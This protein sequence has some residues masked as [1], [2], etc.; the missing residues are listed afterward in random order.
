MCCMN[1]INVFS[2][3]NR[4]ISNALSLKKLEDDMIGL[5]TFP[6][7]GHMSSSM[8]GGKHKFGVF[9]GFNVTCHLLVDIVRSPRFIDLP[10]KALDPLKGSIHGYSSVCITGEDQHSV[11]TSK[12][13]VNV[14]GALHTSFVVEVCAEVPLTNLRRDVKCKPVCRV[15]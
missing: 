2:V 14:K 8:Y 3:Y 6:L 12:L 7:S 9:T 4:P 5:S 11:F 10:I 1:E 15:S 13:L